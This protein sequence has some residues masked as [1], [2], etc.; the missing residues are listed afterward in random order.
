MSKLFYLRRP[1]SRA[2]GGYECLHHVTDIDG[3]E[4]LDLVELPSRNGAAVF[5]ST[6]AYYGTK[7]GYEAVEISGD[8]VHG[9]SN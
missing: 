9:E 6:V 2:P 5:D 1:E 4:L 8:E 3:N 7:N